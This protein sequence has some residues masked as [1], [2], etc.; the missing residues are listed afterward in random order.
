MRDPVERCHSAVRMHKRDGKPREGVDIRL[1]EDEAL[2][3]YVTGAE[4]RLRTEYHHTLAAI[5][6]V[7]DA[8]EVFFGFYETIFTEPEVERLSAFFG[9]A[10]DLDFV[11]HKVNVS[12]K[13]KGLA[14]ET[15]A[16]VRETYGEVYAACAERF[17]VT[18]EIWRGPGRGGLVASHGGEFVV[19]RSSARFSRAFS[20][21]GDPLVG[22]D[23]RRGGGGGLGGG[24][25]GG[26][27]GGGGGGEKRGGGGRWAGGAE[28]KG[29]I[30]V[31]N[32]WRVGCAGSRG[33]DR[34]GRVGWLRPRVGGLLTAL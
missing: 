12:S 3:R 21:R 15:A 2:R 29:G 11:E 20:E 31:V 27:G 5:D 32:L 10:P 1:D 23:M 28:E 14:P 6:A 17:P 22:I 7:F 4:A 18:R 24:G 16:F 34:D 30:G 8:D 19:L 25:F 26:E 33:G 13:A 9:V